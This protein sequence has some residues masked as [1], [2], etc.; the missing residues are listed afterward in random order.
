MGDFQ[1][2]L[3]I[4]AATKNLKRRMKKIIALI[5]F[6]ALIAGACF[7]C[8]DKKAHRK[9]LTEAA[10][11]YGEDKLGEA[12]D[13]DKTLGSIA[14]ALRKAGDPVVGLAIGKMLQ[15]DNYYLFSIGKIKRGED[16]QMVSFGIYGHVFTPTTSMIDNALQEE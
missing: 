2:K 10:G 13:G 4:F 12:T 9:A 15:V 1:K 16:T 11:Q 3:C 6:V 5:V 7:T 14:K 8:P